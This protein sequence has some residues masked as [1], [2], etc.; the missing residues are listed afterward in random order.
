MKKILLFGMMIFCA[1]NVL[2]FGS[3]R[4]RSSHH[5]TGVN[6]IGVHISSDSSPC[7]KN[8]ELLDDVCV[9]KCPEGVTRSTRDRS[10][11]ICVNENVYLSYKSEPCSTETP[12]D[13]GCRSNDD[14]EEDE[15]C[16]IDGV[17][18]SSNCSEITEGS[19]QP[20]GAL[21]GPIEIEGLGSV[22]A[23]KTAMTWWSADNW[24]KAQGKSLID[25]SELGCHND[26]GLVTDWHSGRVY[27][28]ASEQNCDNEGKG[29][30]SYWNWNVIKSGYEDTVNT[31]YSPVVIN[32]RKA[33]MNVLGGNRYMWIY[34]GC[35]DLRGCTAYRLELLNGWLHNP[36]RNGST[37][38]YA[39]CK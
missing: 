3:G 17:W 4:S 7:P 34:S 5:S 38:D 12:K 20:V 36:I 19:C 32:L 33:L 31:L 27:C 37:W 39:V 15:F 25:V 35:I 9:D 13:M 1:T 14:C 23:S 30:G 18:T 26:D 6:S 24:C 8:Q 11:S 28:C 2:A 29:W 21:S 22:V 16:Q 10:C